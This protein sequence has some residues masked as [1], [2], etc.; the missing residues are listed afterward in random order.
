VPRVN[1][2]IGRSNDSVT[3][4]QRS[5]SRTEERRR[6]WPFAQIPP[7]SD[8]CG[9]PRS[10]AGRPLRGSRSPCRRVG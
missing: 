6:R 10:A 3:P 9:F 2:P 4:I 8:C 5:R 7:N 1:S